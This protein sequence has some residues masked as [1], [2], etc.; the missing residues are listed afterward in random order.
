MKKKYGF[1]IE[2]AMMYP[3]QK[4]IQKYVDSVGEIALI[5]PPLLTN[6]LQA[7]KDVKVFIKNNHNGAAVESQGAK[8]FE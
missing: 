3:T 4:L 2:H 8:V 5:F 1:K 7:F 6:H